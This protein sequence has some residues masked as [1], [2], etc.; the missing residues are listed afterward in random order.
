MVDIMCVTAGMA[1]GAVL[2]QDDNQA[3]PQ[4]P[5]ER[6]SLQPKMRARICPR[7]SMDA[8]YIYGYSILYKT[9]QKAIRSH[10]AY[11]ERAALLIAAKAPQGVIA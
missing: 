8:L 11:I 2:I 5:S 6:F 7:V 1:A 3:V 4:V 10:M 9:P